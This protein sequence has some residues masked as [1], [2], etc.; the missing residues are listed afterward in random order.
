MQ[1]AFLHGYLEE[2]YMKQSPGYEDKSKPQ[3]VCKLD[4]ALYGPK[5]AP[6]TWYSRLSTE[7]GFKSSK[8]DTSLFFYNKGSITIFLLVYAD[9]IIVASSTQKQ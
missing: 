9:D 8:A 1:N 4:K 3:Y 5:K 7:L 6:R 2:V